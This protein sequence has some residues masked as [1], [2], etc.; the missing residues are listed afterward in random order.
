MLIDILRNLVYYN[1]FGLFNL[2]HYLSSSFI[3]RTSINYK[4][5]RSLNHY[6]I[7]SSLHI[8]KMIRN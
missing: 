2:Y 4:V 3:P 5:I 6:I 1:L 7:K 8:C